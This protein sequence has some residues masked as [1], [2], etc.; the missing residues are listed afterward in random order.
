MGSKKVISD[1]VKVDKLPGFSCKLCG[2]C[3]RER[4]IMLYD[5]DVER[6]ESSGFSGFYERASD[7]ELY[8]TGAPYRMKLKEDGSC[9]FLRSDN[10][11]SIYEIRPD[12]CRRYPFIIG[13]DFS[14]ASVSCP[15][16]IWEVEGDPEP[17]R[18][19][20]RKIANAISKFIKE[21]DS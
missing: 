2:S 21:L 3:C 19:P 9:F 18:E 14:L 20:S 11:C 13:E 4:A 17:F 7:L 6:I 10:K 5:E 16:I 1:F 15:G 12:T 8:L